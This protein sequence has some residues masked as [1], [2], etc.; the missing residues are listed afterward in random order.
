[1]AWTLLKG[2]YKNCSH[3]GSIP[4]S[5]IFFVFIKD[6]IAKN[7]SKL[8]EDDKT[9]KQNDSE[10]LATANQNAPFRMRGMRLLSSVFLRL[11]QEKEIKCFFYFTYF[12]GGSD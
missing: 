10:W 1:M 6:Q 7:K 9:K 11:I 12:N 4:S 2:E 5:R 3:P 8:G